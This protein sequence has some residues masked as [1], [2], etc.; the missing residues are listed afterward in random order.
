MRDKINRKRHTCLARPPAYLSFFVSTS[1]RFRRFR[2]PFQ[3]HRRFG[4]GVFTDRR[5]GP[6][7]LFSRKMTFFSQPRF[8]PQN[9]G[10]NE[11]M[12]TIWRPSTQYDCVMAKGI[13]APSEVIHRLARRLAE[14]TPSDSLFE[15]EFHSRKPDFDP[16]DSQMTAG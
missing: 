15:A 4:E 8:F 13:S 14:I 3:R 5:R 9:L 2:L 1:G 10:V 16:N 12:A 11:T 7:E 6:Q